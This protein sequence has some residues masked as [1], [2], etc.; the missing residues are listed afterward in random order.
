MFLISDR[1]VRWRCCP[2]NLSD[3]MSMV[4]QAQ[5]YNTISQNF[6]HFNEINAYCFK[7][8]SNN[9]YPSWL[10]GHFLFHFMHL[11][12][13]GITSTEIIYNTTIQLQ[14]MLLLYKYK[15]ERPFITF[16]REVCYFPYCIVRHLIRPFYGDLH[17]KPLMLARLPAA[18]GA[19]YYPVHIPHLLWTPNS[20]ALSVA[21]RCCCMQIPADPIMK[22]QQEATLFCLH[23]F[24]NVFY[25]WYCMP[26]EL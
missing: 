7:Q 4:L 13:W 11:S 8:C 18:A 16:C 12:L 24:R 19:C 14:Y 9:E 5:F 25:M 6:R 10:S 3:F 15:T 23:S 26:Q 1:I 22:R 17:V 2:A 20:A 21:L